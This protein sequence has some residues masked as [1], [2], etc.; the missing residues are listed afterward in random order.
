QTSD[1]KIILAIEPRVFTTRTVDI[2]LPAGY[3]EKGESPFEAGR[4]E[5]MEE[6]G[7][8]S[9]ELIHLGSFY[10]DQGCSA[11]Y[12]HY[13]L[14][15]N[16]KKVSEQKL[17]SGEFIKYI[18]VDKE[19]LEELLQLGYINGLNSAYTILKVNDYKRV[20]KL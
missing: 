3:I 19:E 16:C 18:L 6:T 12:N 8:N 20:R 1:G 5:L 4:R 11:A 13:L 7:Y 10:Q 17:D 14:A 2:G 15:L 9:E